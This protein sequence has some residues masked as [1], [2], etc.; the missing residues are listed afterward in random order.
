MQTINDCLPRETLVADPSTSFSSGTSQETSSFS[1]TNSGS[2]TLLFGE[3]ES[4]ASSQSS[5]ARRPRKYTRYQSCQ[6]PDSTTRLP[7]S[8]FS[9]RQDAT[10]DGNH[11]YLWPLP[12]HLAVCARQSDRTLSSA[13][14]PTPAS[15]SSPNNGTALQSLPLL[16]ASVYRPEKQAAPPSNRAPPSLSSSRAPSSLLATHP[17]FRSTANKSHRLP[18]PPLVFASPSR[19]FASEPSNENLLQPLAYLPVVVRQS[20]KL[21][22]E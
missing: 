3:V 19:Q 22:A 21:N 20:E 6:H 13:P 8:G 1:S 2:S 7:A 10:Q 12:T 16:S 9:P 14:T 4:S 17:A 18:S 15:V 5:S 11:P